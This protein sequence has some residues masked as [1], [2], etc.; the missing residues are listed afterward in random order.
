[1]LRIVNRVA[2]SMHAPQIMQAPKR[3]S[4]P[5]R[6]FATV[7]PRITNHKLTTNVTGLDVIP[8]AREV[9]ISI[10]DATIQ[11]A[12]EYNKINGVSPSI[13]SCIYSIST[14]NRFV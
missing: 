7:D 1:M 6:S 10:Y 14:F 4:M 3:I 2:R 8:N 9:L 13:Q 5:S 12:E 11:K